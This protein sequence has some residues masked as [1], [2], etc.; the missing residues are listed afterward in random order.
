MIIEDE[1][2]M[3]PPFEFHNVGSHVKPTRDPNRIKA[4][5]ERYKKI[6]DSV[7]HM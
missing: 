6:E 7:K 5:L 2:D 4:L 3:Y 1:R